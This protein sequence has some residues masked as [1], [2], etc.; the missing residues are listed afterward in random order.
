MARA[1]LSTGLENV[2]VKLNSSL[3]SA[4]CAMRQAITTKTAVVGVSFIFPAKNW[5]E[6]ELMHCK[7]RKATLTQVG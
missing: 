5:K 1:A 4:A 2:V 7:N 6:D 3:L